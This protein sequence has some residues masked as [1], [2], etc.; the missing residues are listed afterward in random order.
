MQNIAYKGSLQSWVL[1]PRFTYVNRR[2][3]TL[4]TCFGSYVRP[5]P[6]LSFPTENCFIVPTIWEHWQVPHHCA[7][8]CPQFEQTQET[9]LIFFNPTSFPEFGLQVNLSS[10]PTFLTVSNVFLFNKS[11]APSPFWTPML[12]SGSFPSLVLC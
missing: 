5:P 8:L 1:I 10:K 11:S 6:P 4:V 9:L 2:G 7:S 12:G 3:F